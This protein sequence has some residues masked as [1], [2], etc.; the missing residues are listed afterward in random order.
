[1]IRWSIRILSMIGLAVAFAVWCFWALV[2]HSAQWIG[3]KAGLGCALPPA[4]ITATY[5][6]QKWRGRL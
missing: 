6:I 1:M 2:N 5:Q 3:E 4:I